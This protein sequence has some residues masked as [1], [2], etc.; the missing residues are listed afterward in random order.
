MLKWLS[1]S[2][3]LNPIE[4]LWSILKRRLL[5]YEEQPDGIL[6]LWSRIEDVWE[7]ITQSECQK[8]IESMPKRIK[9]VYNARGGRTNY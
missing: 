9:A 4:N 2:P 1:H 5:Q 7:P 6:E 8:L 3:N